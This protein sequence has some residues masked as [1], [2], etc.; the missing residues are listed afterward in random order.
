MALVY[1]TSVSFIIVILSFSLFVGSKGDVGSVRFN[2]IG[3]LQ[4]VRLQNQ[5][6][7]PTPYPAAG[8]R[9]NRQFDLP[10]QEE[11]QAEAEAPNEQETVDFEQFSPAQQAQ[12]P[13]AIYGT[14][15][16]QRFQ[17]PQQQQR[18]RQQQQRQQQQQQEQQQQAQQPHFAY[19]A[20]HAIYDA[21]DAD[22]LTRSATTKS[23]QPQRLR[24]KPARLTANREDIEDDDDD[25]EDTR[26][27]IDV[28]SKVE[29]NN[30][31]Q[32]QPQPQP[33]P[34]PQPAVGTGT[35]IAYFP[36]GAV[37]VVHPA[38]PAVSAA[39]ITA[40]YRYQ[41]A[42]ATPLFARFQTQP[43][44]Y[45]PT[46]VTQSQFVVQPQI[47]AAPSAAAAAPVSSGYFSTVAPVA[48]LRAAW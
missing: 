31:A 24:A 8:F 11:F 2:R 28:D 37:N 20:P 6:I 4:S 39:A 46:A 21:P 17:S 41:P 32:P 40:A 42:A 10:S 34:L 13:D 16:R 12:Q 22:F 47:A 3:R 38:V 29:V 36:A 1:P 26:E 18:Q 5:Q 30:V 15:A 9:P 23:L 27:D 14:P 33:Q 44:L 25:E 7:N 45:T 35:T 19:A 48:S 43:V